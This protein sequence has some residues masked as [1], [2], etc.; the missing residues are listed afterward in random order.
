MSVLGAYWC[1]P[2]LGIRIYFGH[3]LNFEEK[4]YFWSTCLRKQKRS[5]HKK[6]ENQCGSHANSSNHVRVSV[7]GKD[8]NEHKTV[9]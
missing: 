1:K 9:G 4:V 6:K 5:M 2:I 8:Y 3:R 7:F